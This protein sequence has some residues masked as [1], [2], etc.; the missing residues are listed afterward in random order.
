MKKDGLAARGIVP[1]EV[2]ASFG[3]ACLLLTSR[4]VAGKHAAA[5]QI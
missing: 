3:L 5:L 1:R 2:I 4:R